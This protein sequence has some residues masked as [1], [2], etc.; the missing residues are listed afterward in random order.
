MDS[1]VFG[2]DHLVSLPDDGAVWDLEAPGPLI[3]TVLVQEY[4]GSVHD[5]GTATGHLAVLTNVVSPTQSAA[6]W[7]LRAEDVA[8]IEDTAAVNG[9]D[10]VVGALGD[11][12]Q[13]ATASASS[14]VCLVIVRNAGHLPL[15]GALGPARAILIL[16]TSTSDEV[17][18]PG[19]QS[20]HVDSS[21][22]VQ[23]PGDPGA[24]TLLVAQD[25]LEVTR[26][27]LTAGAT[28]L[29]ERSAGDPVSSKWANRAVDSA[30]RRADLQRREHIDQIQQMQLQVDRALD[31]MAVAREECEVMRNSSSWRLTRPFREF[32]RL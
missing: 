18:I 4:A 27:A 12:P 19:Y 14:P 20:I 30:R 31:Q 15:V 25:D 13:T 9:A 8:A 6:A 21:G 22:R 16:G 5:I 17:T 11:V 10:I 24:A 32:K 29:A 2:V 23:E 3:T 7:A 26:K 1:G 28:A